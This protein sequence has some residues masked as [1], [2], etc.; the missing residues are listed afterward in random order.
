MNL[1]PLLTQACQRDEGP[2]P[3]AD[4]SP[5]YDIDAGKI[6]PLYGVGV[7][8]SLTELI[9]TIE[10]SRE[11]LALEDGWDGPESIGIDEATWKRAIN[12]VVMNAVA[13]QH[14]T[15]ATPAAPSIDPAPNGG[16]HLDWTCPGRE[17]LVVIP[18]SAEHVAEYYADDGHGTIWHKGVLDLRAGNEWLF[19]WLVS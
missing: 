12:F 6:I 13:V 15:G 4:A 9:A 17:L 2:R 11:L 7:P 16:I 8:A 5:H 18:P 3:V 1:S 14:L 19:V 10:D